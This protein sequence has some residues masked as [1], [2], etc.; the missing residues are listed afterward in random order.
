M[1]CALALMGLDLA[2][3]VTSSIATLGN[4]GPGLGKVGATANWS[5]L[6]AFAKWVMSI[7]M[8]LGRLEIFP[9]LVLLYSFFNAGAE[10][11]KY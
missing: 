9:F 10:R 6:P 11:N 4:I 7:L 8:L 3:A 5:H 1:S 2:I